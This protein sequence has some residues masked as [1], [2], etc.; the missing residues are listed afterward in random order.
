MASRLP[1]GPGTL[2][3]LRGMFDLSYTFVD[4]AKQ[5]GDPFSF[6]TPFGPV[7]VTFSPEGNKAIFGADPDTFAASSADALSGIFD[8]S[9]LVTHGA[10]HRRQRKLLMPPFHGA[11][12]RAYGQLMRDRAWQWGERIEIGKPFVMVDV[13]QNITLDV[14]IEAV[15]G[16]DR[17]EQVEAFRSEIQALLQSFSPFVFV[18][19]LRRDFLGLGPWARLQRH[20]AQIR[21]RV[22]VLC[23]QYRAAP[24]GRQDILSL[25]LA[26]KDEEGGSLSEKEIFDQLLTI[27]FAGHETTAVM[28]AWAFYCL[29]REPD[30][31]KA[32]HA[33]L[34]PLSEQADPE[35]V[36]RL[37]YLEAVIN[38]T[39]RLY[40]PVHIIHRRLLKP[41]S[42]AGYDLQPGD[43]VAAGAFVTHRLPEIYPE[44]ERF[45]P[46]RFIDRSYSAFEFLPWGGGARR[47]LGAAFAMYEMKQ[48]IFALLKRYRF[49]L[50]ETG[51]VGFVHRPGT[52]GPKGGIRMMREG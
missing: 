8:S 31:L 34:A 49:K 35:E 28:L 16:V 46:Q 1:K 33:E 38:E 27:L 50:L 10:Q 4:V 41:L 20:L 48:V 37:P 36:A 12:M 11:R 39:L 6:P 44:P 13:T 14:I 24:A 25:L 32:L 52:V 17:S 30:T 22:D 51:P 9:V 19:A 47:C 43:A 15:F 23:Q 7:V 18:K 42:L 2:S 3:F 5:Y 29:H 45:L 26:A 40:P 21:T